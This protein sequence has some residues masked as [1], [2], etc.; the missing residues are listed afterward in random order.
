MNFTYLVDSAINVYDELR[1]NFFRTVLSLSAISIGI[2]CIVSVLTVFDSMQLYV[3]K[4]LSSLG[5]NILYVSKYPWLPEGDG[6]YAWWQYKS[7]PVC[8]YKEVVFLKKNL[9]NAQKVSIS[10]T[11][12]QNIILKNN[13]YES[14]IL[15][16]STDFDKLTG[17]DIVRGR[18]FTNSELNSPYHATIVL[19]EG[20]ARSL[21][22][23]TEVALN[24]NV[25][26][27]QQNFT[28]IGILKKQGNS[29][30]GFDFDNSVI[31]PY[32]YLSRIKNIDNN[33]G[34]GFVDPMLMVEATN[35]DK[36]AELNY[37]L[38]AALRNFRNLKPNDASTFSI[39]KLDAIQN[40]VNEIFKLLKS[41]G[42]IIGF[43]AL[44]VGCFSIANIMYVSVKEKTYEIGLKKAV[45]ATSKQIRVDILLESIFLCLLGGIGG[46]LLVMI[47]T[48][49]LSFFLFFPV[50]L[51]SF[52]FLV[53]ISVSMIV[54]IISGYLPAL[55]ASK[56]N[57][58]TAIRRI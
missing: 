5:G 17:I 58:V 54:G 3:Q 37:E 10:Y 18:Y 45:G 28:I 49:L 55:Q 23:S 12:Q 50:Y 11:D 34:N 51:T 21:F 44:L 46:L 56:L 41:G 36:L 47:L 7:R 2:F 31:M 38:S 4:N 20:I 30:I 22:Q 52:N 13:T 39:N 8:N 27:Y 1:N 19:G 43:F 15:A 25:T 24:K 9:I 42:W 14:T 26:L 6:A 40:K 57:P 53:G 29:M 16:V 32:L 33:P 48:V 35:E